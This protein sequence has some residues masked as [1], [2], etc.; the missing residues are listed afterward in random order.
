MSVEYLNPVGLHDPVDN[1][2]SHISRA[3]GKYSY[4]IGGQVGDIP[5]RRTGCCTSLLR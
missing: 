2:Y 3:T 4:R 1:M 5:H